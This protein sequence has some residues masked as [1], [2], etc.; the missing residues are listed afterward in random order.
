MKSYIL[1][2]LLIVVAACSTKSYDAEAIINKSIEVSGGDNYKANEVQFEF[3][4][5]EYGAY[6]DGGKYEFVRLFKDSTNV[7]RDVLNN[8]GF[9][10]EV[11]G[12]RTE[13]ADTMATKYTSSV[14]SAIYFALLPFNLGDASV[15][16]KY[17]EEAE[18]KGQKYHKIQVTFNQQGGGEDF[19]D[20]FIYWINKETNKADYIAYSYEVDGGGVR[21]REA[22]NE[23]NVGGIRFVDYVN[24][25]PADG[26]PVQDTGLAFEKGQLKELSRIELIKIK[27]NPIQ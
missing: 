23:R 14:N 1:V 26:V 17:L 22:Y 12:H 5:R 7:V 27:V 20:I 24:Y 18:I 15:N 8:N 11:N 6:Y 13:V 2:M 3:R 10:R 4:G 16:K 25:K 19:E 9:Y 21:F